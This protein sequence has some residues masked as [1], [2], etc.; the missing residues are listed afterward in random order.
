MDDPLP[1]NPY[2]TLNVPK[3]ATLA[4]IRSAH[5]KLV[6][7]CHPDKV[8]DEAVK[9]IKGE[10]FHQVQQAYEILS[11]EHR[12]QR[13]DEKVKLAELRAEV[14][15][16][17]GLPRRSMDFMSPRT[18]QSP[19]FEMR[20]GRLYEERV[21]SNSRAYEEDLFSS[22]FAEARSSSRKYDD[23]F[24]EPSSRRSSGRAQDDKKKV[25][26]RDAELDRERERKIRETAT[27]AADAFT[28]D[29]KTRRRDKDRRRDSE[30]NSR[31]KFAYVED[32]GSDSDMGDRYYS[33]RETTT[34]RRHEDDRKRGRDEPRR[35]GRRDVKDYDDDLHFDLHFKTKSAEDYINKSKEAV[36]V[37]P[38]RRTRAA[39]NVDRTPPPPPP[40]P[41]PAPVD[42]GKRSSDRDR[43]RGRGSRAPSPVRN[44]A[45]EKRSAEIVDP[46]PSSRKASLPGFTSDP[47]GL[48]NLFSPSSRKEAPL[49]SAT[50]QPAAEFKKP[51]MR[52]A[53]TMPID[54]MRRGDPVPP[55]SSNLRK[56]RA[57]SDSSD[58]SD[59]DSDMT[60]E[61]APRPSPRQQSTKYK[62]HEDAVDDKG[63]RTFVLEPED[64]Y[65]RTREASPKTRRS[66][67]RPAMAARGSTN[68]RTPPLRASSYAFPPEDRPSPRQGFARTESAR[69]PPLSKTYSS[70][71]GSPQL[72]GE[73]SPSAE[74]PYK[75]V[76]LSPKLHSDDVRYSKPYSRRGSED[77]DR[78]AYPGSFHKSH[79]RP[80]LERNESVC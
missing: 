25:R 30:A 55:K 31:S 24:P 61:I 57:L 32:D 8:Q 74:E 66:S 33:K 40:P 13:Y 67:D 23:R 60:P 53:E 28:R 14:M 51:T 71:R 16:E 42:S 44:S 72:F 73:Y 4:T 65:S 29:Q 75:V 46:P 11:D 10:Q 43:R 48:K 19:I 64:I 22:K 68:A 59:T 62:I 58:S 35:N 47:K 20:G 2:K 38:R 50:Y 17:R 3:D 12:R 63:P 15:D 77:V 70:A 69:A 52:R 27:R 45:K 6:L 78:D 18:G 79:R 41:P 37:E 49:R 34:K 26:E 1:P 56:A 39:S 54:Q 5:R 80:H 7:L 21:P 76:H 36:D 9:K